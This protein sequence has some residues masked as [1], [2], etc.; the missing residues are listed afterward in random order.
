MRITEYLNIHATHPG[1]Y[2][3]RKSKNIQKKNSIAS[4]NIFLKTSY[5]I[6]LTFTCS[7]QQLKY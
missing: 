2:K 1:K 7:N 5:F 6:R 4:A 3:V